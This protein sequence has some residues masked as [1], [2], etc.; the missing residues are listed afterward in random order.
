MNNINITHELCAEDRARLDGIGKLLA[1]L[2]NLLT[3]TAATLAPEATRKQQAPVEQ[4]APATTPAKEETPTEV[5]ESPAEEAEQT[6]T[7]AQI[8]Q[9]V[10]QLAAC[11]GETDKAKAAAKKAKVRGIINAYA[12]KVSE[13]PED[14]WPEVW[15]RL[16]ALEG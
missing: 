12:P 9:K 15:A 6:V 11:Q 14:K 3:P 13:L 7:L 2:I 5:K 8:Q 1:D 4:E 16:I 10:T